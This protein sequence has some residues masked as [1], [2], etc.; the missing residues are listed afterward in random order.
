MLLKKKIRYSEI[1]SACEHEYFGG[2]DTII[3]ITIIYFK[4]Y[5]LLFVLFFAK[6]KLIFTS[7]SYEEYAFL[8]VELNVTFQNVSYVQIYHIHQDCQDKHILKM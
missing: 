5:S 4:I 6:R 7:V 2:S 3:I 1:T 8:V